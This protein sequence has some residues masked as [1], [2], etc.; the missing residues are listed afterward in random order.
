MNNFNFH[1]HAFVD[2]IVRELNSAHI[3]RN[4]PQYLSK[5]GNIITYITSHSVHSVN[6]IKKEEKE[7]KEIKKKLMKKQIQ[8][9]R[10]HNVF[11]RLLMNIIIYFKIL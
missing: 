9:A 3:K 2:R 4:L 1:Y 6:E 7:I 5:F 11:Y 8:R 10:I